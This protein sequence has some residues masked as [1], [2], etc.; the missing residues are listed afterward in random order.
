M[1][2]LLLEL[3]VFLDPTRMKSFVMGVGGIFSKSPVNP[4]SKAV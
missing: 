2:E 4:F 3:L 1:N